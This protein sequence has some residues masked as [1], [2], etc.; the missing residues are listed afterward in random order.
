[1]FETDK[2]SLQL[3]RQRLREIADELFAIQERFMDWEIRFVNGLKEWCGDF[4]PR[5]KATLLRMHNKYF[6]KF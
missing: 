4:T 3:E 5:Q 6:S 2:E 1:M